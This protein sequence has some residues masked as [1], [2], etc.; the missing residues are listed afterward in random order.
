MRIVNG[1]L[2]VMLALFAI[3]Q[4]NDP[5]GMLWFLVYG[6]PA[7][8]A[9]I[10]AFRPDVLAQNRLLQG[11]LGVC[12]AVAV[13]GS[14]Y[15]WPSEISTWWDNEEVRE[16]LGLIIVTVALLVVAYGVWRARRT[17]SPAVAT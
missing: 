8:W 1:V 6:I 10:A 11:A 17:R 2:C 4:Y 5:D 13:L 16:G 3:A 14:I 12:L 7:V 9:G 15:M